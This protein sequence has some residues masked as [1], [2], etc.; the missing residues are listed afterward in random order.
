VFGGGRKRTV[1]ILIL[2]RLRYGVRETVRLGFTVRG[3][4]R[5][6]GSG[7]TRTVGKDK[8]LSE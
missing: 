5:Q 7:E 3:E 2:Q 4:Q 6:Y 1:S 8:G